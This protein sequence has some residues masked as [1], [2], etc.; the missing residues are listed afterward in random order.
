MGAKIILVKLNYL[1]GTCVRLFEN[2][3]MDFLNQAG[4]IVLFDV[5]DWHYSGSS[6]G[7]GIFVKLANEF[8]KRD[9]KLHFSSHLPEKQEALF[10]MLGI[11]DLFAPYG[12]W[13]LFRK[14]SNAEIL[15]QR[16]KASNINISFAEEKIANTY[17]KEGDLHLYLET[18]KTKNYENVSIV[19]WANSKKVLK[20]N[21][22]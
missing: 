15:V 2:S 13:Q 11:Y 8:Q 14:N 19:I 7:T 3:I 20:V 5:Q 17:L 21:S 10:D 16:L 1:D 12:G 4:K 22:L 9:A 6:T 18:D